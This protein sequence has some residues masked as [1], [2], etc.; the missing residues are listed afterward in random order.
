MLYSHLIVLFTFAC[1][2]LITVTCPQA[3]VSVLSVMF[4]MQVAEEFIRL[5]GISLLEAIQYNNEDEQRLRASYILD[6]YLHAR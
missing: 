6:H 3:S 5:D 1:F 4:L 2:L